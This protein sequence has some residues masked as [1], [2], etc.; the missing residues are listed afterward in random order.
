MKT[1]N[2]LILL[3]LLISVSCTDE[4]VTTEPIQRI[5]SIGLFDV[6]NEGKVSDMSVVFSIKNIAGIS[7]F[8]ILIIPSNKSKSFT[9]EEAL[10]LPEERFITVGLSNREDYAIRLSK[11][12][13]IEGNPIVA[14]KAY[15]AK[16]LMIGQQFNQLSMIASDGLTLK[17]QGVFDGFYTGIL[18]H[19]FRAGSPSNNEKTLV[20][21][22]NFSETSTEGNYVGQFTTS[23]T[24]QGFGGFVNA[25]GSTTIRLTI[26]DGSI[27]DF[28]ADNTL[29][30]STAGYRD[31]DSGKL[32]GQLRTELKLE[33]IGNGCAEGKYEMTLT[34]SLPPV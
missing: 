22:G 23:E 7:Q 3:V 30:D 8:N 12:N 24:R 26:K 21:S 15:V 19:N 34:R 20:L 31:C 11:T 1:S 27:V 9:K 4:N 2:Y 33:I 32:S 6:G 17:D 16:I 14:N 28:S 5:E 18:V 25:P 29:F 13:D 10:L